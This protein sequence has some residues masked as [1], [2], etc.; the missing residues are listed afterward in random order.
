MAQ[1]EIELDGSWP[2]KHQDRVQTI[3][4]KAARTI[5]HHVD[6]STKHEILVKL[7]R[8]GPMVLYKE[9]SRLSNDTVEMLLDPDFGTPKNPRVYD[10]QL[11][12]QFGQE[13]PHILQDYN[14]LRS[15]SSKNGWW[16]ET[17]C[18]IMGIWLTKQ[19]GWHDYIDN[20]FSNPKR[21]S[22]QVIDWQLF[23][24]VIERDVRKY[25]YCRSINATIAWK[26]YPAFKEN[27]KLFNTYS[28]LPKSDSVLEQYFN[29]W[30]E[31][32][33]LRD[34]DSNFVEHIKQTLF[35][36]TEL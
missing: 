8:E 25:P 3:L 32:E 6:L 14:K 22:D 35:N 34:K 2:E 7:D 31:S 26:L 20:K 1:F 15:S 33:Q 4:E 28:Y 27:P 19:E 13:I 36:E 5:E 21:L 10:P 16:H 24:S 18:E 17:L 29:E 9:H 30:S 23:L 11:I 12:Y